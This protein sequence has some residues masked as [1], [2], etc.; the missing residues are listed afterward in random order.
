MPKRIQLPDGRWVYVPDVDLLAEQIQSRSPVTE[1]IWGEEEEEEDEGTLAGSAWEGFKSI[2][3][4]VADVFLSGAQAAIGIATP[5]ADLPVERRLRKQASKRARERDPAYQDA[6]LPAVG[7]GLGQVAALSAISR[8][9]GGWFAAMGAGVGM[10]ISEQTRRIADYEQRT[11]TNVPWYKESAAHLMGALIGLTEVVPVKGMFP[12]SVQKMMERMKGGVAPNSFRNLS[13][14]EQTLGLKGAANIAL[15]EAA[16]E[17]SANWLQS[18][19][20]RGLYDPNAMED[21]ARSMAEDF[22]VGG[23]VGG[24]AKLV[25][26]QILGAKFRK[27]NLDTSLEEP[28]RGAQWRDDQTVRD[29][30]DHITGISDTMPETLRQLGIEEGL[31]QDVTRMFGGKWASIPYGLDNLLKTGRITR[32]EVQDLKENFNAEILVPRFN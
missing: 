31:S 27:W 7:T 6:F 4:G 16:Q 24:I 22:K 15:Q 30:A 8:L 1:P 9:P 21:V 18:I 28:L 2:P 19:S 17:A 20:A 5:F 26:H 13:K 32:P 14:L 3:S 29:I 12:T 23:I 11:G 25:Q 10:G